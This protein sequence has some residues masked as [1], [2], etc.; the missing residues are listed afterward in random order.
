MTD[1]TGFSSN[2][3]QQHGNYLTLRV[4][5]EDEDDEITVELIN[6]TVGHP[7]TLDADRNIVLLIA[8]KD[9]QSVRVVVNH[10]NEDSTISTKT[11]TYDL[12]GL[13]LAPAPADDNEEEPGG[14]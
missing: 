7:V 12:S 14:E 3:D 4:D 1:Y 8:D 11:E 6:G 9:T 10:M 13:V 2:P 5:T